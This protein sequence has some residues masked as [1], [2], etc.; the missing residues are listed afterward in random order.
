MDRIEIKFKE[1][2]SY[3][4]HTGKQIKVFPFVSNV[5]ANNL[6]EDLKSFEGVVGSTFRYLN[7][8]KQ[9]KAS[10]KTDSEISL[11]KSILKNALSKVETIDYQD[12]E[13]V[14]TTLYFDDEANLI[15]FHIDTLVYLDFI[16]SESALRN[17]SRFVYDTFFSG[18]NITSSDE[19]KKDENI[20]NSLI[21]ES[22]PELSNSQNDTNE[23]LYRDLQPKVSE[24]FKRDL[25]FLKESNELFL[26][27]IED[28]IKFYYFQYY[29]QLIIDLKNFGSKESEVKPISFTLDWEILSS[30]RVNTQY[31]SWKNLFNTEHKYLFVHANVIE[32]LNYIYIDGSP[33]GDYRSIR[34][35]Y[36]ELDE[37]EK[38]QLEEAIQLLTIRYTNS[39]T[40]FNSGSDWIDCKEKL[41]QSLDNK[42]FENKCDKLIYELWYKV[43]YQFEHSTRGAASKRYISW[44]SSFC[45][46]NFLKNR[47][48]LG[49]V[50][51]LSQEYL[52]FLTR[53]CIGNND[54]IRLKQLWVEFENRGLHFDESSKSE[55]VRLFEKINLIEKK[56]DSGDAQYVKSIV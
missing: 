30:S 43:R 16:S 45:D 24:L 4:H 51:T 18:Q 56:S 12:L 32:L 25:S 44:F 50:F 39:L 31:I 23:K 35:L 49:K 19:S 41:S 26:N 21:L 8:K 42:S 20:L 13:E 5:S 40:S 47:G 33:I 28:L 2:K 48:R 36:N 1:K 9:V 17:I 34:K 29:V 3:T 27:H 54:K 46:A 38:T 14:L 15:K 7:S 10:N 22:L 11:K 55:I 53:L 6:E 37:D 52:L